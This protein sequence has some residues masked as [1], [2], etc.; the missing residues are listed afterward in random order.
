MACAYRDEEYFLEI[1]APFP[2]IFDEPCFLPQD[3]CKR[4][5][6]YKFYL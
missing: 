6:I 3:I 2:A 4:V 5:D 1:R